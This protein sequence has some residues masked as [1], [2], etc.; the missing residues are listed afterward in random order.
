MDG[1][2]LTLA[3]AAIAQVAVETGVLG[4]HDR[5]TIVLGPLSPLLDTAAGAQAELAIGYGD[6]TETVITGSVARVG[7][8]PWGTCVEVLSKS[9]AL[10][11]VRVGRS[12]VQQS[13]GD[14]ARDLLGEGGVDPGEVDGGA[15]LSVYHV[16]E[17]RSAWQHLRS[18]AALFGAELS[19]GGDGS[20]NLHAARKGS[21]DLRLRGGADFLG[22]VAGTN[23]ERAKRASTGPFSAASEQ[24]S[25]AWSLVHHEPGG[26]GEHALLA[27]IRDQ[28]GASAR[29]DAV[30]AARGRA[31]GFA[32]AS[33]TGRQSLRA[34]DL[35]ELEDVDRAAGTYRALAVTHR[36]DD[37]GFVTTLTL[38][39]AA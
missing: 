34:G 33:V 23:A 14:I 3:E 18:L 15:T 21:A 37:G 2:K 12:Y 9:A 13:V 39:G 16:H 36:I 31:K 17:R 8:V 11:G 30:E 7:Q 24:G 28:D 20:V 4:Q 10:D 27:A 29:D 35:V 26:S 5:A 1:R 22:W 32:R 38:E 6:D 25:D 19:S